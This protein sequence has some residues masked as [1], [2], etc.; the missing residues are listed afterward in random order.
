MSAVFY[1]NCHAIA[2]PLTLSPKRWRLVIKT[3]NW[4]QGYITAEEGIS[5]YY[6]EIGFPNI[7][8]RKIRCW[9]YVM[10]LLLMSRCWIRG[11]TLWASWRTSMLPQKKTISYKLNLFQSKLDWS[12]CIHGYMVCSETWYFGI[13]ISL[14]TY[15]MNL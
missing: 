7:I 2:R 13:I 5:V 15:S 11:D 3:P 9:Q 12:S 1:L 8:I 4:V 10:V 6:D 14:F